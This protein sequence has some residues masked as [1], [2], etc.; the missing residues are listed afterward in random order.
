[1]SKEHENFEFIAKTALFELA[2]AYG[3]D[4]A[5][6]TI[7]MDRYSLLSEQ[8]SNSQCVNENSTDHQCKRYKNEHLKIFAKFDEGRL[9]HYSV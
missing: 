1:M 6:S 3:V 2:T 7:Y 8:N 4:E 9:K 5:E